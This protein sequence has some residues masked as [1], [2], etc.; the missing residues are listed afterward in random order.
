MQRA[1]ARNGRTLLYMY[2]Y[3]FGVDKD[4]AWIRV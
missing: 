4:K 1:A 3:F 2:M